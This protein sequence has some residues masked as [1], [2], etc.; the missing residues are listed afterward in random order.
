MR[1]ATTPGEREDLLARAV[2][3]QVRSGWRLQ[4]DSQFQAVLVK[5]RRPNHKLHLTLTI[6]TCGLWGIVWLAIW[7]FGGEQREVLVVD[8]QGQTNIERQLAVATLKLQ[9]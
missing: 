8:E 4:A 5:G 3:Q 1:A 9:L 6:G 7:I 2:A